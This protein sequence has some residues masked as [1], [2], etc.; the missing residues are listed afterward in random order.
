[1][2]VEPSASPPHA[3]RKDKMFGITCPA[4]ACYSYQHDY[5]SEFLAASGFEC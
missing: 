3:A 4:I 1:M 2:E 5:L